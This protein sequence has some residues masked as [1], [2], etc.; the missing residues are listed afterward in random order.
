MVGDMRLNVSIQLVNQGALALNDL[1][2]VVKSRFLG[3]DQGVE[4]LDFFIIPTRRIAYCT[5]LAF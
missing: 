2:L 4:L 3:L 5:C 1:S